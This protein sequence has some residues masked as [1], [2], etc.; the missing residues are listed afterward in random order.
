[1]SALDS[2]LGWLAI[3][4]AASLA[5]M[6]WPF[7]RGGTGVL[8]KMII[9][10]LGAVAGGLLGRVVLP[11]ESATAH[12]LFAA[13]GALA[14]LGVSQIAWHRHVRSKSVPA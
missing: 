4:A 3:G 1:M 2:V 6:I 7:L 9:G 5:G 14:L 11:N 13:V 10:P 8:V 12:L